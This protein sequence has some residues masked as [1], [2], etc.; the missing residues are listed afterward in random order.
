MKQN[1]LG[2]FQ[3]IGITFISFVQDLFDFVDSFF[4][5]FG[6]ETYGC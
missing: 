1:P 6:I 3:F 2:L 5:R 4:F